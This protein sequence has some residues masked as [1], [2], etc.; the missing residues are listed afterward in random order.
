MAYNHDKG[1]CYI[2]EEKNICFIPIPKNSSTTFRNNCPWEYK[3]D[4][5]ISNPAV[6]ESNT[7][8]CIIREP[9]ERFVSGYLE[10]LIRS[11]DSPKTLEKDFFYIKSEPERFLEFIKEISQEFYDA[12]IEPQTYYITDNAGQIVKLDH[13]WLQTN[14]N[15]H[16]SALFEKQITGK[17]NSKNPSIKKGYI[18]FINKNNII[19]KII[20]NMYNKD[21][22]FYNRILEENNN[23]N[24]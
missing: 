7:V 5:F 9:I 21:I 14:T 8:I 23:D 19:K 4:N 12:H 3:T 17:S 20:Q 24:Q 2:V 6:L 10:V 16:F 18:E 15:K 1:M 13:I 11:H 22:E